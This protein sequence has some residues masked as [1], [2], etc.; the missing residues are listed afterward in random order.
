MDVYVC[1]YTLSI[2]EKRVTS[3]WWIW[4][5]CITSWRPTLCDGSRTLR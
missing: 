3:R 1:N 5:C 2:D 4:P